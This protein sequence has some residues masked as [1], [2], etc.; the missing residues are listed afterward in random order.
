EGSRRCAKPVVHVIQLEGVIVECAP[1]TSILQASYP[2]VI[3]LAH[4]C[5]DNS[6]CTICRVEVQSG[7]E[8]LSED[9]FDEQDLLDR[10][11]LTEAFNRLGCQAKIVGD[12]VVTVPLQ[13]FGRAAAEGPDHENSCSM[14]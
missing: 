10:E 11:N 14:Q 13:K 1:N 12:V 9:D 4:D 8:N 6:S 2:L 3:P 5:G 7:G